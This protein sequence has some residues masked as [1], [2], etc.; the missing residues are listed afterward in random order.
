MS[1]NRNGIRTK[2]CAKCS[3]EKEPGKKAYCRR[4]HNIYNA[5]WRKANP[6]SEEQRVKILTRSKTHYHVKRGTITKK[7]CAI[8]H[9]NSV[10]AH[11]EDYSD[12]LNVRWL[13]VLCHRKHHIDQSYDQWKWKQLEL[14]V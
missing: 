3:Q 9:E 8:C 7:P 5:Q 10:Q 12:A 13:C 2:Y 4:C 6:P 1:R 11:H 14:T